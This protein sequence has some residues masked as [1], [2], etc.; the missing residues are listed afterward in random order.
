MK[1]FQWCSLVSRLRL[2]NFYHWLLGYT[3]A[4]K[5]HPQLYCVSLWCKQSLG[6]IPLKVTSIGTLCWNLNRAHLESDSYGRCKPL[7]SVPT[8]YLK[9]HVM[10]LLWLGVWFWLHCICFAFWITFYWRARLTYYPELSQLPIAS[11]RHPSTSQSAS[12][13]PDK[14]ELHHLRL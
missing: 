9:I 5:W 13:S 1:S 4:G 11:W 3:Q 14:P 8:A 12:W 6:H 7:L 10:F 2:A